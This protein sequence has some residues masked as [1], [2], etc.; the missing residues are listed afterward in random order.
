MQARSEAPPPPAE[1]SHPSPPLF[2]PSLLMCC[3]TLQADGLQV[4]TD[5]GSILESALAYIQQLKASAG[6]GTG[7]SG[8]I[9]SPPTL[10]TRAAGGGLASVLR[11]S[12]I[13]PVGWGGGGAGLVVG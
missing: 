6:R 4:R 2:P 10:V 9:S 7:D 3:A 11:A 13:I 5:R 8:T 1:S 12:P